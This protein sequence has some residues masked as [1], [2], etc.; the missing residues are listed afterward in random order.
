MGLHC[1]VQAFSSWGVWASRGTKLSLCGAQVSL[2][3][4][5]WLLWLPHAGLVAPQN[6][7]LSSLIR[8]WTHV[9]CIG[10]QILNHWTTKKSQVWGEGGVLSLSLSLW[11]HSSLSMASICSPAYNLKEV[12]LRVL[13]QDSML[14][15]YCSL[16][17]SVTKLGWLFKCLYQSYVY[18]L[19]LPLN[20]NIL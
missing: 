9:P 18:A 17:L 16:H 3:A 12:G 6:A 5:C 19:F 14:R 7:A 8:D 11:N 20:L 15:Y 4:V 13:G 1:R 2:V 10:R